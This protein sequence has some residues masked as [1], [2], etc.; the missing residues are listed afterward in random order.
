MRAWLARISSRTL[1]RVPTDAE[2]AAEFRYRNPVVETDTL[3]I[4]VSQSGETLDTLAAVKEVQ[5]KGGRVLGVVNVVGSTIARE[6]DGGIYIHAGPEVSV[7]STKTFTCTLV[8]FALFA[9]YLGRIRDLSP[10]Y[11]T[12][13]IRALKE[14]PEQLQSALDTEPE[15]ASVAK[16]LCRSVERV[17]HRSRQRLPHRARRCAEAQG[18]LLYSRRS[19]SCLGAQAWAAC[20]RVP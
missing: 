20:A 8:A 9:L 14:L 7:A 1:T 2:P 13:L 17:L 15:I 4:A 5:R 19:L 6:V 18:N 10:Q 16:S 12:R 3:Y 11:G